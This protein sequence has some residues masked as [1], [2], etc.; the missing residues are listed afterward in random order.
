M[1]RA[2]GVLFLPDLVV[3]VQLGR[4]RVAQRAQG[5]AAGV[6]AVKL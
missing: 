3:L 4:V 2:G 1:I 5:P 6:E